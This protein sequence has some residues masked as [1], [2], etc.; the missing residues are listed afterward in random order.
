MFADIDEQEKIIRI[1]K[2]EPQFK[3]DLYGS[4]F[5]R[6]SADSYYHR[7]RNPHW[8]PKGRHG[9]RVTELTAAEISEYNAGYDYNERYGDKKIWD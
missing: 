9:D 3:R 4:L 2:D 8:W 7:Q 1:L 6:G 5:D